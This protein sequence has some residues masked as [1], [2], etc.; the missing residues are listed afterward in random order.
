[1]GLVFVLAV[2]LLAAPP[3]TGDGL[4]QGKVVGVADGDTITVLSG[5]ASVKVRLWGIDSPEGGQP[6]GKVAKRYASDLS[7]GR[8][9]E[10]RTKDVDRYG[11]VVGEVIL[12]GGKSL[13]REMVR[14]G[15]AWWYYD[16][17]KKDLELALLEREARGARRG[18][19]ADPNPVPPWAWRRAKRG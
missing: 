11:R 10:V 2:V 3:A 13:N 15:F 1:M 5:R 12:P 17:A 16:Y 8:L 14:A 4:L 6:Y 18:L 7:Y 19:W 9:V